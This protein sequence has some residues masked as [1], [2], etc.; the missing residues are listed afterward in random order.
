[1]EEKKVI[2]RCEE[3]HILEFKEKAPLT[4]VRCTICGG[5]M[6]P[7]EEEKSS[8]WKGIDPVAESMYR[9]MRP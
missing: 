5:K 8:E 9:D 4:E 7:V 2:F 1:M 6:V 3:G